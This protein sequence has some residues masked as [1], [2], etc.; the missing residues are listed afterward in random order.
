MRQ[1]CQQW[2]TAHLDKDVSTSLSIFV[3]QLAGG[4]VMFAFCSI[5]IK[6]SA[7]PPK[8]CIYAL[9]ENSCANNLL[10]TA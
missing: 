7:A 10:C 1:R 4:A 8:Y 2:P 9:L 3:L 5:C 6:Q